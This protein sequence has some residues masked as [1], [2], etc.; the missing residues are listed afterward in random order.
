MPGTQDGCRPLVVGIGA[1]MFGYTLKEELRDALEADPCVG[2]L[3]DF[4]V[5]SDE[6][7]RPYPAVGLEVAESVRAG[8]LDRAILIC[9]TGIGMAISANKVPGVRAT[10]AYDQYSV[11]RSVLSNDCQ[12]LTLGG[13][14][15]MPELARRIV[16]DWLRYRFDSSSPSAAKLDLIRRYEHI[17]AQYA[18]PGLQPINSPATVASPSQE[19]NAGT[20]SNDRAP[21][22]GRTSTRIGG[23]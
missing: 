8:E 19:A 16:K 21:A 12:V 18:S 9:G 23:N 22:G 2:E 10:V 11:E 14:V 17:V 7:P 20:P 4:G 1:D 5:F 15:V 6:D 3:R 13:K